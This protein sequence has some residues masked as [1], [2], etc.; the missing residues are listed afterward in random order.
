MLELDVTDDAGFAALAEEVAGWDRL[1]GVLHSIAFAPP[2]ALGKAFLT[3]PAS[4]ASW[5][6]FRVSAYSFGQ[7]A[8][9][10]AP[11][12]ARRRARRVGGRHDHR[13]PA[14]AAGL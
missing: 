5:T 11:A 4:S 7:L 2:D 1:D 10:L 9:A 12:L 8:Q 6:G 3:T 13:H 14:G